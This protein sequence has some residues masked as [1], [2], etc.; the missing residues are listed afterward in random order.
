MAI[1]FLSIAD[2]PMPFLTAGTRAARRKKQQEQSGLTPEDELA[3]RESIGSQAM[4]G[5]AW[6]GE[7]LDKP[8]RAIRG[9]L[10]GL[11][12]GDW[13]GGLLNLLPFS[14]TLGFT[15]PEEQVG[16][17][18]LLETLGVLDPNTEGLDAGDVAGFGAEVLLDPLTYLSLGGSAV[19]K[20]GK[21]AKGAGLYDDA[22]RAAKMAGTG[23][24]TFRMSNTLD[25]LIKGAADPAVAQEAVGRYAKETGLDAA[26]LGGEKLGGQIGVGLPFMDPAFTTGTGPTAQ[27]IAGGLDWMGDKLRYGNI[28]GTAYSPGRHLHSLFD[29]PGTMEASSELGQKY[30][31]QFFHEAEKAKIEPSGLLARMTRASDELAKL[32]PD[33]Q[34]ID[35]SNRLRS[36]LEGFEEPPTKALAELL[37]EYTAY[38]ED[39]LKRHRMGGGN[40]HRLKDELASYFSRRPVGRP[41]GEPDYLEYTSA[42]R[43]TQDRRLY[44]KNIEGGTATLNALY[45]DPAIKDAIEASVARNASAIAAGADTEQVGEIIEE[46]ADLIKDRYGTKISETYTN[47]AGKEFKRYPELAKS[48]I[49]NPDARE[50]G[51]FPHAP[52]ADFKAWLERSEDAIGAQ[53]VVADAIAKHMVRV[54]YGAKPPKDAMTVKQF[55]ETLG[56][57]DGL[58]NWPDKWLKLADDFMRDEMP[59]ALW[60][61]ARRKGEAPVSDWLHAWVPK[62]LADDMARMKHGFTSPTPANK[63]IKAVDTFTS[64]FKA[65]VLTFPARISRDLSSALYQLWEKGLVPL[66]RTYGAAKQGHELMQ[67]LLKDAHTIPIVKQ[68]LAKRGLP[69][70]AEEGTKI[71]GE[72]GFQYGLSG[73]G[74]VTQ[75]AQPTAVE[76]IRTL[77]PFAQQIP[78]MRPPSASRIGRKLTFREPG[79]TWNPLDVEGVMDAMGT[80]REA[81][82]FGIAAGGQELSHWSDGV[83]RLGGF[84]EQ[85]RKGVAPQEAANRVKAALV[86]YDPKRLTTF[87]R[88]GLKRMFPFFSFTKGAVPAAIRSLAEKPGGKL[89]QTIRGL[90]QGRDDST[91][92]PDYVAETSSFR[93]PEGTPLIGGGPGSDPRFVTGLG[94]MFE[95]ML[96]FMGSGAGLET[97]SRTNPLIKGPLEYTVGESFFQKGPE[98]GRELSDMDPT[99]GR[100]LANLGG[101]EEPVKLPLWLEQL[102]ANLPT[103]RLVSTA[104]TLTDP[105][106]RIEGTVLPGAAAGVNLLTGIRLNDVSPRTSDAILTER[107]A[108]LMKDIGAKSFERTY[109][110][111]DAIAK[112]KPEVRAKAV[113]LEQLLNLLAKRKREAAKKRKQAIPVGAS[114]I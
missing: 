98:G 75:I 109:F 103:S 71:L 107:A 47:E 66:S 17:R 55:L 105:R 104:R 34:E 88:E 53:E 21:L 12:G 64:L 92:V 60:N 72:M 50:A 33:A 9:T 62:K 52:V 46:V 91:L 69:A 81:T 67:G 44:L 96:G 58:N 31:E 16:G 13:G 27:K 95:D 90:G 59:G 111:D 113:E 82:K 49:H 61:V 99:I 25:D 51:L 68:E 108:A 7:T 85:L 1:D 26:A 38:A 76:G 4:G 79:T 32:M 83:T 102:S 37:P 73:K 10:S 11:S 19:S 48:I 8:G 15:P 45:T 94:L 36:V 39:V 20:A 65:G 80:P 93:I 84:I 87:E 3:L 18:D 35:V 56:M 110:H 22:A 2:N 14:D 54:P 5:L 23:P 114:G 30:G 101:M 78:G 63:I 70:T 100:L 28:P 40:V 42:A 77:E 86:D 41:V 29:R 43:S 97:L 6:L 106:K 24:R 89:A 57:N 74:Q 112:M